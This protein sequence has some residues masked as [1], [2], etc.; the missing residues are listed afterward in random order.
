M[1]NWMAKQI[2]RAHCFLNPYQR[3]TFYD[4][5]THSF[6]GVHFTQDNGIVTGSFCSYYDDAH[7][8][9]AR[10]VVSYDYLWGCEIVGAVDRFHAAELCLVTGSYC[11]TGHSRKPLR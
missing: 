2:W 10:Q 1:K 5:R 8:N 4:P 6:L 11:V 9:I 7:T 3:T